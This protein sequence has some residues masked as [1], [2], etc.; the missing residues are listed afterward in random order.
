M[1]VGRPEVVGGHFHV[2]KKIGEGSFGVI[3]Q[4]FNDLND[5][6]VAIKF[7]CS[8]KGFLEYLCADVGTDKSGCPAVEG[9]VPDVQDAPWQA[10][11]RAQEGFPV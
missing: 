2:Q 10:Y 3:Y 9:R 8:T 6:L 4:G 1:M 5:R 7:V 11:L